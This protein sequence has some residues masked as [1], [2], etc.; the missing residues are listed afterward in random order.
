MSALAALLALSLATPG[1]LADLGP[2]QIEAMCSPE[3][4][5]AGPFG[6]GVVDRPI[7]RQSDRTSPA[8]ALETNVG[9][10]TAFERWVAPQSRSVH[11]LRY[12]AITTDDVDTAALIRHLLAVAPQAGWTAYSDAPVAASGPR[13]FYKEIAIDGRAAR[14]WLIADGGLWTTSLFCTRDDL[15]PETMLTMLER[16]ANAVA[17]RRRA[18]Q[19]GMDD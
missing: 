10:F 13:H 2:E 8:Y 4:G 12:K 18:E 3:G 19:D 16:A 6:E 14:L 17:A 11:T 9:P 7:V 15:R 1:P 5:L